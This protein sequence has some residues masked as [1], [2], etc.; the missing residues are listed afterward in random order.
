MIR[1]SF[2]AAVLCLAT[3]S[4]SHA[5]EVRASISGVIS[6]PSGAPIPGAMVNATNV[7]KNTRVSTQSNDSGNY[8][9]PFLEPGT[10]TLTVERD[11]FKRFQ[12][13]QI[14]LQ[15]LDKARVDVQLQVGAVSESVT[16]SS[17]VSPLQTET[18]SRSQIISN[19]LIANL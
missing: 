12:R 5:Q 1:R 6:D 8:L 7:S 19:E 3:A 2:V 17:S 10:Y 4:F 18:A 14:I 11:G 9:T 15:T 16:V 13:E